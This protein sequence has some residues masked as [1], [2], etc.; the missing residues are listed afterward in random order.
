[1]APTQT[2]RKHARDHN[3]GLRGV[4]QS[5]VEAALPM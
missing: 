3:T 1:M 2:P 4:A 5:V